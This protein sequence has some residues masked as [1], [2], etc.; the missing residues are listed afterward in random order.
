MQIYKLLLLEYNPLKLLLEYN[1]L[2]W[3]PV[4]FDGKG[5]DHLKL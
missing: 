3:A 5:V 1:P 4:I 2:K